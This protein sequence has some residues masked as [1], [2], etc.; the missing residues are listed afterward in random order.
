MITIFSGGILTGQA[1][2]PF[3]CY[4]FPTPG[5]ILNQLVFT[6]LNTIAAD[7]SNY[8]FGNLYVRGVSAPQGKGTILAAVSTAS[9]S[10]TWNTPIIVTPPGGPYTFATSDQLWVEG[11]IVGSPP[12]P[13]WNA[14]STAPI[15]PAYPW[16]GWPNYPG[17]LGGLVATTPP[18]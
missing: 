18:P 10:W 11:G 14:R 2:Q 1:F 15:S 6:P 4:P 7:P 8:F 13:V 3:E 5:L 16:N 17:Y 9:T 12:M